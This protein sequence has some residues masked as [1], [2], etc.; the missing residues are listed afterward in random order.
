MKPFEHHNARSIEEAVRLLDKYDGKAKV[1]A[2]G[3]DLLGRYERQRF[4]PTI[5]RRSST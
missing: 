4:L 5:P 1:N 2:G 3:T